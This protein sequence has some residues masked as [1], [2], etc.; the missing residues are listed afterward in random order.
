MSVSKDA[1][2]SIGIT[3][4]EDV[5]RARRRRSLHGKRARRDQFANRPRA[6]REGLR[7]KRRDYLLFGVAGGRHA[8]MNARP[9]AVTSR[10]RLSTSE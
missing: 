7:R 8:D 2:V 4:A 3:G 9:K 10:T 5:A 6:G 1:E